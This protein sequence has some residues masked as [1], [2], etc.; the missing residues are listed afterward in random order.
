[1]TMPKRLLVTLTI[2]TLMFLGLQPPAWSAD[3]VYRI[4]RFYDTENEALGRVAKTVVETCAAS[5]TIYSDPVKI[6][7]NARVQSLIF[8]ITDNGT[9]TV[10]VR[11]YYD[12]GKGHSQSFLRSLD[13]PNS[14]PTDF[15]NEI[16]TGVTSAHGEIL[17]PFSAAWAEWAIITIKETSGG[18][19]KI[20]PKFRGMSGKVGWGRSE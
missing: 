8:E 15:M 5:Q 16:V 2:T 9:A 14:G 11:L 13:Y 17:V 19:N 10:D 3:G 1:M 12:N 4:L 20:T 6:G 18:S 7:D